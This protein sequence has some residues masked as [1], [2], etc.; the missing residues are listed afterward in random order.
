MNLD[1]PNI[2]FDQLMPFVKYAYQPFSTPMLE[3]DF[4]MT[5]SGS[6]PIGA[7]SCKVFQNVVP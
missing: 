6:S 5:S 3:F 7:K 1:L 2:M 4:L